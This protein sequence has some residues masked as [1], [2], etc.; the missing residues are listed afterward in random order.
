MSQTTEALRALGSSTAEAA[1]DALAVYVGEVVV[2]APEMIDVD[3]HPLT[4]VAFPAFAVDVQYTDGVTGGNVFVMPPAGARALA[5]AMLGQ[6]PDGAEPD[7]DLDELQ[8]SAV[9]EAM[10]QMMAA[11]AAATSAVLGTDVDISPPRTRRLDAAR[12]ADGH[13]E[14]APH[15]VQIPIFVAGAACRLIQ[16]VPTA[17]VVRLT[18]ALDDRGA[19]IEAPA[20]ASEAS[21][22]RSASTEGLRAVGV[23]LWVELGRT[24]MPAGDLVAIPTGGVVALDRLADDP[25]D[26]YVGGMRFGRGRLVVVDGSEW[27]VR[28]EEVHGLPADEPALAASPASHQSPTSTEGA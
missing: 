25:V 2:G 23:D 16:L 9:G 10:N 8:Q 28:I 27:A 22:S 26:L 1:A 7:A 19:E 24:R 3:A 4:G 18:R 6:E 5:E 17:F 14:L 13:Y 15:V 11:A 21:A 20:S 12:E